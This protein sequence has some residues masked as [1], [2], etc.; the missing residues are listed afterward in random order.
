MLRVGH[1]TERLHDD[2]LSK[3][4]LGVWSNGR[5]NRASALR[6]LRVRSEFCNCQR[7]RYAM[8]L[9]IIV[10]WATDLQDNIAGAVTLQQSSRDGPGENHP[11]RWGW[12]DRPVGR[13]EC[14]AGRRSLS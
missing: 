11:A 4:Y 7:S 8:R 14:G 2:V 6:S 1:S 10:G 3:D 13:A 9:E 5:Q 12:P